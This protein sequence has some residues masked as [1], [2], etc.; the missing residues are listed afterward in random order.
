MGAIVDILFS[1]LQNGSSRS[2]YCDTAMK[3]ST[4]K[5]RSSCLP[6][7]GIV[8]RDGK[9]VKCRKGF[10][11]LGNSCQ[12]DPL[13]LSSVRITKRDIL[14]G[15]LVGCS[16]DGVRS[17]FQFVKGDVFDSAWDQVLEEKNLLIE[18]GLIQDRQTTVSDTTDSWS[19]IGIVFLIT[20]A[21]FGIYWW[22]NRK[23]TSQKLEPMLK[24]V[25]QSVKERVPTTRNERPDCMVCL[26]TPACHALTCGHLIC[27]T[28]CFDISKRN[29]TR[30]T[31]ACCPYCRKSSL[32]WV[33]IYGLSE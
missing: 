11:L 7:P 9:L 23:K 29:L 13:F 31:Q 27:C 26:N 3:V 20:L 12:E 6:C 14:E 16:V 28:G 24:T 32:S 18:N 10:L 30:G 25:T 8:C 19:H 5:Q 33:L 22:Y 2:D 1:V 4:T 17:K 15:E 21:F